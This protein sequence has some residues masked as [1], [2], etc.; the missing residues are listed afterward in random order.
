MSRCWFTFLYFGHDINLVS[1]LDG[2]LKK[3]KLENRLLSKEK[4]DIVETSYKGKE[5]NLA[6]N[7]NQV[8]NNIKKRIWFS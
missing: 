1:V 4:V 5:N 7:L 6:I 8:E 2:G 3:W